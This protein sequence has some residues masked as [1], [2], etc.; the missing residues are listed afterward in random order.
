MSLTGLRPIT[1]RIIITDSLSGGLSQP[2]TGF[3]FRLAV[4]N[5]INGN[6]IWPGPS[7]IL[8]IPPDTGEQMTLVSTSSADSAAGTGIRS[9]FV[10]YLDANGNPQTEV[11]LMNGTNNVNTVAT[12]IRFV[13]DIHSATAG[14]NLL[15]I[16]SI[17]IFKTGFPSTIYNQILPGTN[18]SLNTS[19]MVPAGKVLLITQFNVSGGSSITRTA[20]VRMRATSHDGILQPRLFHFIDDFIV[21]NN[22]TNRRYDYPPVIPSFGIVKC[23]SYTATGG[24]DI[25]SSWQG[26]L[27]NTP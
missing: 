11:V 3:G 17:T 6:D 15:A 2:L 21:V 1:D 19:R 5:V 9:V 14:S 23:T 4:T 25:Q 20:D 24:I 26:L 27:I 12:N 22:S 7:P 10:H 8:P 13:Q 18:Q 16:G